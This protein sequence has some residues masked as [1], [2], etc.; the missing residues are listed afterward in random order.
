MSAEHLKWNRIQLQSR[1]PEDVAIILPDE[2]AGNCPRRD[3]YEKDGE[4]FHLFL[5]GENI[6]MKADLIE[7]IR[8]E[9]QE[10]LIET[11]NHELGKT[12]LLEKTGKGEANV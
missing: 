5:F 9:I 12:S 7:E 6:K 3:L 8:S 10:I 2:Q 4:Q 1:L 11:I